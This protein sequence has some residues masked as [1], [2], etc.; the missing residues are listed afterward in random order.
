M[1]RTDAQ[2]KNIPSRAPQ[3]RHGGA[4]AHNGVALARDG[5]DESRFAAA[6]RSEDGDVFAGIHAKV[7]VVEDD[8]VAANDAHIFQVNQCR[9][10][11]DVCP[12]FQIMNPPEQNSV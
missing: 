6:V 3:D 11:K 12:S 4:V 10:H 2:L 7:E 9:C 8:V 5:F 1:P